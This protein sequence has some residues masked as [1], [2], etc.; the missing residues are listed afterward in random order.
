MKKS[1]FLFAVLVSVIFSGVVL[2]GV[3]WSASNQ[4]I[5]PILSLLLANRN[6]FS[7]E[8]KSGVVVVAEE[9]AG[10]IVS[11]DP[12]VDADTVQFV[13]QAGLAAELSVGE[14]FHIPPG[15]DSRF[16]LGF[17][18]IVVAMTANGDGAYTVTLR[19]ASYGD[20][21]QESH[22]VLEDVI[23]DA[24]NFV[25]V[26]APDAVQA[27]SDAP[28]IPKQSLGK[29]LHSFRNGAVVVRRA[30]TQG[31]ASGVPK[32]GNVGTVDLNMEI[33][34]SDMGVDA[35]RARPLATGS[36][37]SI[38][39]SGSL[40]NL[41]FNHDVDFKRVLFDTIPYGL[42]SMDVGVEGLLNLAVKANYNGS[43][44]FGYFS[45]AWN[46]VKEE[47]FKTYG[48]SGSISGINPD[49]KIGKFPLAGLVFSIE[50]PGTCPVVTGTTQTPLRQAKAM[51]VIV[52][53]C[54][55]FNGEISIEGNLT[56]VS[57]N[58]GAL[59]VGIRKVNPDSDLEIVKRFYKGRTGE[60]RLIEAP[61]IDGSL[62]L[63]AFAGASVD[64]D[65]FTAG[66]YVA[67]A[68]MDFGSQGEIV[69]QVE[70]SYGSN[71]LHNWSWDGEVCLGDVIYGAG[72]VAR[73]KVDFGVTI[74]TS[75]E[76]LSGDTGFT[77]GRQWPTDDEMKQE[78]WHDLWLTKKFVNGAGCESPVGTV[79]SAGQ[80]WMDRNL[81]ASQVATSSTD[82][83]AY[84]DLYQWGRGADGHQLRTSPTT[85]TTS[86]T[87]AP[88]HGSFITTNDSLYDWRV[89]QNNSLWQGVS[90]ANNPCPS[91]FRLPT[92]TELNTERAS[93][94]S[95]NSAGAYASPLKLVVAG[96]RIHFNGALSSA[97]S[98]GY[99]WSSTV[100]A[101]NA[102]SLDFGSGSAGVYSYIRA[103]GRSLRCLK[104]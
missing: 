94:A 82:S 97:G 64:V 93:W 52:W 45:R 21:V 49:E 96:Y 104:D 61:V 42:K 56:P 40:D 90:G 6:S 89:P 54:S 26:I 9:D 66:V 48:I 47:T 43:V 46:E 1:F 91:G 18:G 5:T 92:E 55:N 73:A 101:S 39:V 12:V 60:K 65:V 20:V 8:I 74:N 50:C 83:A 28:V 84:G 11:F 100:N 95:N 59:A 87:D 27:S 4:S 76:K 34:L 79:T 10:N 38:I 75:W 80:T 72:A 62:G 13:L 88:G 37:A 3:S 30:G 44:K 63:K 57:I 53:I 23:L 99:Y 19:S 68:G 2:P 70:A 32:A 29:S 25:G 41:R 98:Y 78:G 31:L 51:G 22:V 33:K 36:E 85:A 69:A 86:A 71:D 81:G 15:L 16:P 17:T 67:N 14:V 7:T 103:H 35:S 77:F 58:S 102:R 24:S